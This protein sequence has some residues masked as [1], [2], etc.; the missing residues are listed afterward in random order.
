M[1]PE[2][3]HMIQSELEKKHLQKE[4]NMTETEEELWNGHVIVKRGC[5]GGDL[6]P[7]DWAFIVDKTKNIL[8][9]IENF[10]KLGETDSEK[11]KSLKY[12]KDLGTFIQNP[13]TSIQAR[14]GFIYFMNHIVGDCFFYYKEWDETR[15][16]GSYDIYPDVDIDRMFSVIRTVMIENL[17]KLKPFIPDAAKKIQSC[18]TGIFKIDEIPEQIKDLIRKYAVCF[19]DVYVKYEMDK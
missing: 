7:A 2:L 18:D 1:D 10:L 8:V 6:T 4:T 13:K 9:R 15:P 17:E 3:A 5:E 16:T 19:Y 14:V 12:L 11:L